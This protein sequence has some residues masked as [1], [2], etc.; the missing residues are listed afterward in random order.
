MR[1]GGREMHPP[2]G[3]GAAISRQQ[4]HITWLSADIIRKWRYVG[5]ETTSG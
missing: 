2:A 3:T 1:S 4:R 5:C